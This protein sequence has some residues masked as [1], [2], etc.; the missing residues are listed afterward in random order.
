MND[1]PIISIITV[2]YNAE[3]TL[4]R[5]LESVRM[6]SYPHIEMILVDGA[7]PD[8][9]LRI[10]DA[11]NDIITTVVCEKDKGIYDAM[12]KGIYMA[13]GE[14]LLFLNAGDKLHDEDA[15][16]RLVDVAQKSKET[17]NQYPDILYSDTAIVDNEGAFLHLREKRPPEILHSGSFKDGMVVCHQAFVVRRELAVPYDLT[18][19]FSSDFDWCIR[20]MRIVEQRGGQMVRVPEVL[21]DY[22]HEGMTTLNHRSSLKE[23]FRIMTNHY[24]LC[25]T[26][27]KHI[28][29]VCKQLFK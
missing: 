16:A 10:A 15:L 26:V 22:L 5:T 12:N 21:I 27:F 13:N 4:A 11:Y 24:G 3:L 2:T 25:T 19:R 8:G 28:G 14:Y 20:M 18:Y 7:S 17:H 9:T 29:F 23:R 1:F 6:Q